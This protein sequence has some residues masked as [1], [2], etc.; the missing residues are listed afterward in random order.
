MRRLWLPVAA[1]LLAA[2]M[3]AACRTSS[4]GAAPPI[5]QPGA[6]G[7]ASTVIGAEA[8]RDLSKVGATAAD[9][10]FM[11]GMIHHHAQAID[12]TELLKTRSNSDDM[13]KLALRIQVSQTDEIRMMQRWLQAHGEDAPDP[14]AMHMPGMIMPG[15]DHGP[16]MAGMLTPEEMAHLATLKGVEFDRVFLAG[17]IKHHG[18][19]I[20]MVNELFASPGAA[21]DSNIYA[22]AS[23]VVADQQMEI[24]RMSG[25]LAAIKERQ[26]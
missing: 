13:K 22:F 24:D 16:M 26:R 14:H 4:G 12:M 25:M 9:V 10:K 11:Q 19:A 1:C 7:D 8:A 18:G 17:M 20:T 2:A 6:P 23:D 15:M 3:G 5:V 21:Q